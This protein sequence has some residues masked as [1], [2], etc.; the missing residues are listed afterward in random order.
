MKIHPDNR[1]AQS[2][3][4]SEVSPQELKNF[5]EMVKETNW[6]ITPW[7]KGII[8]RFEQAVADNYRFFYDTSW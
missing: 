6:R 3:T 2:F 4:L 5:V 8:K 1:N 7:G